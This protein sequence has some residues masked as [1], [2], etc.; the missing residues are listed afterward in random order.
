MNEDKLTLFEYRLTHLEEALKSIKTIEDTIIRWDTVFSQRGNMDCNLHAE[1]LRVLDGRVS[2]METDING[3]KKFV[4]KASGALVVISIIIQ[5]TMPVIIDKFSG[6]HEQP[7]VR[8]AS[9]S[10]TNS[11]VRLGAWSVGNIQ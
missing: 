8:K 10:S 11:Y 3:L 5:L 6:K 2:T 7:A 1:R 4:Y 9:L